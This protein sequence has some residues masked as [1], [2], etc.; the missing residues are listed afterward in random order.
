MP[1]IPSVASKIPTTPAKPAANASTDNGRDVIY[2]TVFAV[3]YQDETKPKRKGYVYEPPMDVDTMKEHL[4]WQE[5]EEGESFGD[6]Y[7]F[8][9]TNDRKIRCTNNPGNRPFDA[10][11]ALELAQ[12]VVRRKWRFN[13]EAMIIGRTGRT[14]SCQHRLAAG[15]L[16]EQLRTGPNA[17]QWEELWPNNE[18]VTLE[19]VVVYGIDEDSDIT[20]THDNVKPRSLSDVLYADIGLFGT[21]TNRDR[22]ALTRIVEFAVKHLR[23]RTGAATQASSFKPKRTHGEMIDFLNR[24]DRVRQAVKHIYEENKTHNPLDGIMRPGEASAL[25]YLMG[26]SGSDLDAYVA[27]RNVSEESEDV[28]DWSMWDKAKLFW[29]QVC[30]TTSATPPLKEMR[31]ALAALRSLEGEGKGT[32][33]EH[34][35]IV[36]K[37]WNLFAAGKPLTRGALKLQY[38]LRDKDDPTSKFLAE[39]PLVGGIDCG[40]IEDDESPEATTPGTVISAEDDLYDPDIDG[41]STDNPTADEE[42]AML[43]I[44]DEANEDTSLEDLEVNDEPEM[45]EDEMEAR[46]AEARAET[47]KQR[48]AEAAEVKAKREQQRR[49]RNATPTPAPAKTK[50]VRRK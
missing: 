3:V 25:L 7:L 50:P 37:A 30:D 45:T 39:T 29:S 34:R 8:R 43:D 47:E 9:D 22:K 6:D 4:G 44:A 21:M 20:R 27:A 40:G 38:Q 16:A 35:A 48:M 10:K 5:E 42:A 14:L 31:Y 46:K 12:N 15:V 2:D 19:C 23:H 49:N 36:I 32:P 18:P 11:W 28:L 1:R 24:H 26:C 41:S 17:G 13:G 33:D